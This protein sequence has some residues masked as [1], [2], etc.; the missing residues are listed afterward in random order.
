M[1]ICNECFMDDEVVR[2]AI[3]QADA[4]RWLFFSVSGILGIGYLLGI[5]S[6][7]LLL[8]VGFCTRTG[9]REGMMDERYVQE[10]RSFM[11]LQENKRATESG[12]P[13]NGL[14]YVDG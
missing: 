10:C 9:K 4:G 3:K 2:K 5:A 14:E 6:T 8:G 12:K 7:I 11:W 1:A 13:N